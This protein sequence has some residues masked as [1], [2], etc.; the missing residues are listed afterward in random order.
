[1]QRTRD[2]LP[3]PKRPGEQDSASPAGGD[4]PFRAPG[5]EARR[6]LAGAAAVLAAAALLSAGAFLRAELRQA[7][8]E[9]VARLAS[10][11]ELQSREIGA[12]LEERRADSRVLARLALAP[13][14][15]VGASAPAPAAKEGAVDLVED[16]RRAYDY[17]SISILDG[18]SEA[19][20]VRP[21]GA[22]AP[23]PREEAL[24]QAAR[25]TGAVVF[26]SLAASA[27]GP[28]VLAF[29]AP[30]PAGGGAVLLRVDVKTHLFP[31]LS[32][33]PTPSAT[34]ESELLAREGR[35]VVFLGPLRH[36]GLAPPDRRLPL[37]RPSL[38][39]AAALA[40]AGGGPLEGVDY[41]GEACLGVARPVPGT[42]WVLL[43]KMDLSEVRRPMRE[44]AIGI[45]LAAALLLA[46]GGGAGWL[47][48][49]RRQAEL[50]RQR[51][52]AE[53]SA[54][55]AAERLA[56]VLHQASDAILLIDEEDRVIEANRSAGALYG[57]PPEELRGRHP[58]DFRAPEAIAGLEAD[59]AAADRDSGHLFET[60]HLRGDG[61]RVPVE[62]SHRRID[63][64]G[65]PGI[66][67]AIRDITERK[68]REAVLGRMNRMY[69]ALSEVNEA[70]A[71]AAA[72]EEVAAR[73]CRILVETAGFR[74][75]WAG[76]PDAGG[77]LVPQV[78]FGDETGYTR[79]LRVT[80]DDRPEGNGPTGRAFR[81]GR[82]I[83]CNDF[84][85]DPATLPWHDAAARAGI[86]SS[87]ALPLRRRGA[88]AGAITAYSG[89]TG[90]FGARE[91]ALVEEAASALSFALDVLAREEERRSA[92][93]ALEESE[94]RFRRLVSSTP[95]VL[96]TCRLPEWETLFV[97]ENVRAV[98]GHGPEAFAAPAFWASRVH[99]DDASQAFAGADR[100]AAGEP[101]V[102]EYRFRHADG[103]WRWMRDEA[104]LVPS[105]DGAPPTVAGCWLDVTERR[106]AEEALR[107]REELFTSVVSQALDGVAVFDPETDRFLEFNEA[108]HRDLGYSREEFAGKTLSSLNAA[109]SP[110]EIRRNVDRIRGQGAASFET[111][112][113]H[114]NGELRDVL[115]RARQLT[116]HER[117][118]VAAVWTDVTERKAAEAA[119]R[120]SKA[121]LEEA[122]ELVAVGS[123]ELDFAAGS[124]VR[125][126]EIFRIFERDEATWGPSTE[127]FFSAVHPEDR[128][129][130]AREF[131]ESLR[132]GAPS[133][134]EHRIV[135][136]DGAVKWVRARWRSEAAADGRPLRAMGTIQ[137]VTEHRLALEARDLARARDAAEA[138]SR[139][140]SAFL[141]SM[142]HEI[143]TPMNSILGFSQLLL[144][145]PSLSPKQREQLES[146]NRSGEHLLALINDVLEMSKIEA[147][148]ETVALGDVDLYG[149]LFDLE[150]M[151]RLR[152]DRKGLSLVVARGREVPRFVTTDERK[153]RQIL[154]NLVGNAVKFTKAGSVS[155]RAASAPAGDGFLLRFEI[156]D[157]GPGI[158]EEDLPRLFQHFEQTRAG[159]EAGSGTGLGLA[160]S[161]G[162]ARLLG[163]D[164][165]VESR[166]GEGT[167]FT[168]EIPATPARS[169]R[170]GPTHEP[171]RAVRLAGPAPGPRVLV[172]DD[173]ADNRAVLAGMLERVGFEVELA[174]DGEE[175]V[176]A[177]SERRPDLLLIDLRMPGMDGH[178]A[179]RVIRAAEEGRRLP[180]V[181]VTASAFEEDRQRVLAAGADD[182]LRKPFREAELLEK[183]AKLT[184]T[185]F[186]FAEEPEAPG[187]ETA[188]APPGGLPVPEPL[189]SRMRRAVVGADVDR[190]LDL[191]AELGRSDA[192]SAERLRQLAERY[193]YEEILRLLGPEGERPAA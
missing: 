25:E 171:R 190:A 8:S 186:V 140:K 170:P 36:P 133:D 144:G 102:R 165:A 168:V 21:A 11:A 3:G 99:P 191:I 47:L 180:I 28:D 108:A 181:V 66:V 4:G 42:P 62:I 142:S 60:V 174:G 121:R 175:A 27:P 17:A 55:E 49:K 120:A 91:V 122:Q 24:A 9:A 73:V 141:A 87:V 74:L 145:D 117:P 101:V 100:V 88:V 59:L 155:L 126:P 95:A 19:L 137:D 1:M 113:R 189:R 124:L 38:L 16:V 57:C 157:T 76:W 39:G 135:A 119:L 34:A 80:I 6:F 53:R 79:S 166:P 118:L 5:R 109:Q 84:L 22:S 183:A 68:A 32:R 2:A 129:R 154:V 90:F 106:A 18:R 115:V 41:R 44:E 136:A 110:D 112:L 158:R 72:V 65:R 116:L 130:V 85:G 173:V 146:I 67:A 128:E 156:R 164:I 52:E 15:P 192:A 185:A 103:S 98:L 7:R 159:E 92:V 77:N 78:E 161:R 35:S 104:R 107:A 37:D 56:F 10:V 12:W 160:I 176:R 187:A 26:E 163:G 149:L 167:A 178:E 13:G 182:F 75:A 54:R 143:R 132:S 134:L 31:L 83:V 169:E 20:L 51:W 127:A 46:L 40:R 70:V 123:W 151:F 29:A 138:S 64:G 105:A 193:E 48:W 111:R 150:A 114:R 148:R 23:S 50:I 188:P 33:W 86:R 89:E 152:T 172:A 125:S 97:S 71:H 45:A 162:F 94:A 131:R 93:A 14:M 61:S 63:I 69:R 58:R 179:I 147:G 96:Y 153:L 30:V 177:F 82:T 43:A 139:A 81:E 184:G